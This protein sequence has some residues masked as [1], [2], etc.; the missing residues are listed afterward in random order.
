MMQM[1]GQKYRVLSSG[2]DG[3]EVYLDGCGR[4]IDGRYFRPWS[5]SYQDLKI[6]SGKTF[7]LHLQVKG[8]FLCAN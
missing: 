7:K 8:R 3:I 6:V 1:V 5:W 4:M 2:P